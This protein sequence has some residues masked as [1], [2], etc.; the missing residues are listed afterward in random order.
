MH[1]GNEVV[2]TGLGVVSPIGIGRQEF[3]GSLQE[4][5]SGVRRITAFDPKYLPAP[6]GGEVL[7]FDAK[8]YVRPRK[9]LK[10]MSREIQWG[11]GAAEMAIAEAGLSA[12]TVEPERLG[13]VFGG[14]IIYSEL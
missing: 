11:F 2:V 8:L 4:G 3:W 13:V 12:G 14:D 6:F 9:S 5:R 10:V 1:P 7:G